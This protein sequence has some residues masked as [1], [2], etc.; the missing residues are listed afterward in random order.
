MEWLSLIPAV[1][2][3]IGG[4][5][6]STEASAIDQKRPTYDIPKE[7]QQQVN[8]AQ[9]GVYGNMPGYQQAL[10][11]LQQQ[12]AFGINKATNV[13]QSGSDVLGYIAGQNLASNR[14][15]GGL[16][17]NNAQY[18]AQMQARLMSA[19][20]NKAGYE[21]KAFQYNEAQPYQQ[22]MDAKAVLTEGGMQNIYGGVS[23]GVKNYM[24]AQL[25][26]DLGYYGGNKSTGGGMSGEAEYGK[27]SFD[28]IL[29]AIGN[30]K[31]LGGLLGYGG[32][33][34]QAGQLSSENPYDFNVL[35]KQLYNPQTSAITNVLGF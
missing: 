13:A 9:Q 20:A 1:L 29:D 33:Y 31:Y 28:D 12:E 30:R 14:A 7:V 35:S 22:A 25:M 19:L 32:N 17:A 23:S 10:S 24:T 15:L 16:A 6:Q 27:A 34:G 11:N 3:L 4:V 8:I 18:N 2:Q 26:K 5:V 21:D